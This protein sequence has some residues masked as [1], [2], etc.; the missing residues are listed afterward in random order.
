[1]PKPAIVFGSGLI[2]IAGFIVA[3]AVFDRGGFPA[4]ADERRSRPGAE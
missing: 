3:L 1:M 2:V 4:W